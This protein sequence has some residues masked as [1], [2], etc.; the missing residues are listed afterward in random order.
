MVG[1]FFLTVVVHAQILKVTL[2]NAKGSREVGV[3]GMEVW[4]HDFYF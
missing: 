2:G 4:R 3:W 1:A